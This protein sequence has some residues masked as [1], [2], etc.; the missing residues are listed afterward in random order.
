MHWI[1]SQPLMRNRSSERS[2]SASTPVAQTMPPLHDSSHPETRKPRHAVAQDHLLSMSMVHQ[3]P[4]FILGATTR[5]DR[6]R[7]IELA[8]EHSQKWDHEIYRKART[9]LIHLR[10]R[11]SAE[12]AWLPGVPPQRASQLFDELLQDSSIIWK[13]QGLPTL[14]HLN[15]IAAT[16]QIIREDHHTVDLSEL[17]QE[18][19][20]LVDKLHPQDVLR[21]INEDRSLSGFPPVRSLDQV[22]AKL[23]QRKRYYLESIK[24]ALD[25]LSSPMRIHVMTE[26]V[27]TVTSGGKHHAPKLIDDLVDLYEAETLD[28]LQTEAE[29]IHQLI[30]AARAHASS[31]ERTLDLCVE[32]LETAARGWG[33]IAQPIQLRAKARGIDHEAS[34]NLAYAIRSLAIDLFNK[35]DLLAHSQRLTMLLQEVFSKVPEISDRAQEDA[36]ALAEIFLQRKQAAARRNSWAHETTYQ[37]RIGVLFKDALSISPEGISWKGQ[38][39]PLDS[40]TRVRWGG[41]SRSVNG[42]PIGSTYTIAFGDRHSE[43]IVELRQQHI[44]SAFIEKLWRA[45]CVRLLT[46]MLEALK[47][48]QNL[49]FGDVLLHD[50]G[51]TLAKHTLPG[52]SEKVHCSWSQI[53]VWSADG[54]FCIGAKHDKKITAQLSYI[55]GANTHIL[56]RAIRMGVRKPGIRRLS[57]LLVF[58]PGNNFA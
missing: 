41:V 24:D 30:K 43:A 52:A 45:V 55:H 33:K 11:L 6:K 47:E 50:D 23:T 9:D 38:N 54:S 57:D 12:I 31:G 18:M 25:R 51:I 21:D 17:I 1:V 15:I 13:A 53:Q 34:L 4:F 19:A 56:D 27:E 35:Q 36:N 20:Y 58:R 44:Y 32:K 26:A 29:N 37:T 46:E 2:P 7:I 49:C 48:G 5:D 16:F 22:E 10:T 42:I 40:I 28:V 14:A 3:S 8:E 39:F